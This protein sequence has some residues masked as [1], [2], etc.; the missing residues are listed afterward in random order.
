M[1]LPAMRA[2]SGCQRMSLGSVTLHRQ[3]NAHAAANAQR[4]HAAPRLA[5]HHLVEECHQ[6]ARAGRPDRVAQRDGAA[7]D[8]DPLGVE[9]E[10]R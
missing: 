6:D 9:P 5:A 1:A 7:I 3:R 2:A 10:V 8:I 4:R